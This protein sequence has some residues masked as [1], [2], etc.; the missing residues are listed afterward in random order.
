M[1]QSIFL[2]FYFFYSN[3]TKPKIVILKLLFIINLIT[4][5]KFQIYQLFNLKK[6]Y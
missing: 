3:V 4:Y 5:I 1:I 2:Y 6:K